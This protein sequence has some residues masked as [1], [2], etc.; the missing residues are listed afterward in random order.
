MAAINRELRRARGSINRRCAM[1]S[2]VSRRVDMMDCRGKCWVG[3]FEGGV[4]LGVV[5]N[6]WRDC[7]GVW[8][9]PAVA[10]LAKGGT[11]RWSVA[12]GGV[13]RWVN[14]VHAGV[15]VAV[16]GWRWGLKVRGGLR[17]SWDGGDDGLARVMTRDGAWR[18]DRA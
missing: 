17:G 6:W 1:L 9:R 2:R 18:R 14:G 5:A 8:V 12:R 3:G 4:W 15:G 13:G 7:G 11:Y 10:L 16:G